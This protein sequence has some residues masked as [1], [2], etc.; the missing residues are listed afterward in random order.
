[1]DICVNVANYITDTSYVYVNVASSN[2]H[3][4]DT[5]IYV[6]CDKPANRLVSIICIEVFLNRWSIV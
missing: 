6:N 4:V 1:M 5:N 2:I 3:N